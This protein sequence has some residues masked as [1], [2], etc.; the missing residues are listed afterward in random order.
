MH[1]LKL[2]FSYINQTTEI[3]NTR[4]VLRDYI[5]WNDDRELMWVRECISWNDDRELLIYLKEKK[6]MIVSS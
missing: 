4:D 2:E 3:K 1:F 6:M 5:S